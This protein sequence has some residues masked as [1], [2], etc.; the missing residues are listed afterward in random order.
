MK[1]SP[2]MQEYVK[3][4]EQYQDCI[5]LYRLG[6]FYEMFFEDAIL[7]S[8]ELELTL[9][10]KACGLEE[11]A[12]MA[13]MPHHS[14]PTY[15]QRLVE[16]GYKVAICEQLED[17]SQAKGLVKRGVVKVVTPGTIVEGS[18][19]DERKNNYIV[20]INSQKNE[21]YIAGLDLT[22]GKFLTTIINKEDKKYNEV[23]AKIL[24]EISRFTPKEVIVNEEIYKDVKLIEH[25]ENI[26]NIYVTKKSNS[27]FDITINEEE[28]INNKYNLVLEVLSNSI[29]KKDN[30]YFEMK[31]EQ[32]DFLNTVSKENEE[33]IE[34]NEVEVEKKDNNNTNL[35]ALDNT[36]SYLP[37]NNLAIVGIDKYVKET[38]ML[39]LSHI[40]N[41]QMY[42]YEGYMA[43]D[44]IARKNLEINYRLSDQSKKGSLLWVLD[45]TNTSMGARLLS[46]IVNDPLINK[47]EIEKRLDAVEE[48]KTNIILKGNIIELLK[49]VYDIERIA[50]KVA[51][52]S[53]NGKD[54]I[55]LKN[56]IEY[57]PSIKNELKD[58]KSDYLKEIL[59]NLDTLEDIYKIIELMIVDEPPLTITEGNLIK[60]TFD[61][62]VRRLRN[63]SISGKEWIA[64]LEAQERERTDI[65]TLKIGYNKIFGYYLEV[66]NMNKD[67]VPDTYIRKQTLANAERYVTPELKQMEEE[68]LNAESKVNKIEYELFLKLKENIEK[69][70]QRIKRASDNIALIDVLVTFAQVA[71]DNNYIKPKVNTNGI[72]DIKNGRHPVVEKTLKNEDFVDND[73]YL[74]NSSNTVMLITGPNMSGKSTFMRQTALITLMAQIGSFV[75][76]SSAN[77]SIV[78][79]IFTRI[80]ASDDLSMGQSTFMMEMSEVA[81][82]LNNAT[83]NSLVILDEIGRG[84][85][86]YDGMSIA[87]A[88]VEYIAD[89]KEIG[90]KTL[91]ATHYHELVDLEYTHDNIKNFHVDAKEIGNDVIFLRKLIPGG[92]DESYGIHVA[93]LAGVPTKVLNSSRKI[94]RNIEKEKKKITLI[95]NENTED[96]IEQTNL[97]TLSYESIIKKLEKVNVNEITP[98]NAFNLI[99]EL[100]EELDDK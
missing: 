70:I 71:E 36:N 27:Y 93:K 88:V 65:K 83:K 46:R 5:L 66:T 82:I 49:K 67:K 60:E 85:S 64:N 21:V 86:T 78:D 77:I 87:Q 69:E 72:L 7:A 48:F 17:A 81:N 44:S 23:K 47:E 29:Q 6:D 53:V 61:E 3:T 13:G 56:S 55:T 24:D 76:A 52:G 96:L 11:K 26:L 54:M 14:S 32:L 18:M 30:R 20:C 10:K 25:L 80:G 58:V 22:T 4:K 39:E 90:C 1:L 100:K 94:L 95:N 97:F 75:P 40:K 8:R 89:K 73:C 68:L 19:V 37:S 9:T 38:Q 79:K 16:K 84:T 59:N 92:T 63:M 12:P 35:E 15:I 42:K 33:E 91:F 43:L 41:I 45:K 34:V 74:D 2:M 62:D 99:L 51:F 31:L 50:G 28:Q 57:L 98:I